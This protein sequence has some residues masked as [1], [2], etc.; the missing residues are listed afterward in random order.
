MYLSVE[1]GVKKPPANKSIFGVLWLSPVSLMFF[2]ER[3]L[4]KSNSKGKT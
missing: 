4:E 3:E 1:E 2:Q